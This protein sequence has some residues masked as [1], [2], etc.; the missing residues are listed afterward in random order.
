MHTP[1]YE[2]HQEVTLN[3]TILDAASIVGVLD[4]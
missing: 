1:D 4:A 3:L 2:L